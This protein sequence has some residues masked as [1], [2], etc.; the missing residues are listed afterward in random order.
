M[1]R[2]AD[3]DQRCQAFFPSLSPERTTFILLF[4]PSLLSF[5]NSHNHLVLCASLLHIISWIF[6]LENS[7]I[8]S[9]LYPSSP[10]APALCI[11][12]LDVYLGNEYRI[13]TLLDFL[14]NCSSP[15]MLKMGFAL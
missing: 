4:L 3:C 15:L 9:E 8:L 12:S 13:H 5:S 14:P 7:A 6:S 11:L 2:K 1:S 10:P